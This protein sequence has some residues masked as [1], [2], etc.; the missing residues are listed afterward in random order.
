VEIGRPGCIT[1]NASGAVLERKDSVNKNQLIESIFFIFTN[2]D[3][4]LGLPMLATALR[5][6][7]RVHA[8]MTEQQFVAI[9]ILVFG[10]LFCAAQ[11]AGHFSCPF[12]L[13]VQRNNIF[14]ID[15]FPYDLKTPFSEE[16][17][18]APP[19]LYGACAAVRCEG[20]Y[21]TFIKR[22]WSFTRNLCPGF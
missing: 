17:P 2:I 13:C 7:I 1:W 11:G 10:R 6:S 3:S 15:R 21:A 8:G 16:K 5:R 19:L 22:G 12:S 18:L 20:F 4:R 9:C 14:F